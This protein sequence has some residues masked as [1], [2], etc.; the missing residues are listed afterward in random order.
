MVVEELLQ[1]LLGEVAQAAAVTRPAGKPTGHVFKVPLPK[2]TS[3][4][5][6]IVIWIFICVKIS[7]FF[8][9]F[10]NNSKN[11]NGPILNHICFEK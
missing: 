3:R 11:G 1:Q 4:L 5:A 9:I 2:K 8:C 7:H 6:A 10:N